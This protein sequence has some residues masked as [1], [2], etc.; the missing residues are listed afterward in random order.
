MTGGASSAKKGDRY[1]REFVNAVRDAGLGAMRAPS[2]GSATTTALPDVFVGEPITD[3]SNEL[4]NGWGLSRL[5]LVEH[6]AGN[7]TTLYVDESEVEALRGAANTWG[8]TPLLACRFTTQ[9]SPTHHY[10]V[11]PENA[12]RTEQS[13]GLPREDAADRAEV[14]VTAGGEVRR[15]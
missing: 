2:S 10:L 8:G 15:S 3:A 9:A 7:A 6:K 14:I 13:Y 4:V 5:W 11:R 1:E 12:R